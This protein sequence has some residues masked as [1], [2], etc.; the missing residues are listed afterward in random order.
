MN[1][2]S[3]LWLFFFRFCQAQLRDKMSTEE[4]TSA[5]VAQAE[6]QPSPESYARNAAAPYEPMTVEGWETKVTDDGWTYYSNLQTGEWQWEPPHDH[7]GGSQNSEQ[8]EMNHNVTVPTLSLYVRH[9]HHIA[10]CSRLHL[11][12]TDVD[13]EQ[14]N[15]DGMARLA[16][17]KSN[18]LHFLQTAAGQQQLKVKV[19]EIKK[20][21]RDFEKQIRGSLSENER[22]RLHLKRAFVSFDLDE[23]GTL[24]IDEFQ[25]FMEEEQILQCLEKGETIR[26]IVSV[27]DYNQS[28]DIDFDEFM[29]W[30]RRAPKVASLLSKT[31]F[32]LM[33]KDNTKKLAERLMLKDAICHQKRMAATGI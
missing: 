27:I 25:M 19:T 3:P 10:T 26:D 7:E 24:N 16:S 18:V 33:Q 5:H 11:Q 1:S 12:N 30:Y 21:K 2:I 13:S 8:V 29:Q 15:S 9:I 32:S 6:A 4:L 31:L 17:A 23:S 28:G 20:A 22:Q 14:N